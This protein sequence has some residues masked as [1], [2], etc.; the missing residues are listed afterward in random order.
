M[1]GFLSSTQPTLYCSNSFDNRD[2]SLE[3]LLILSSLS[4]LCVR[5]RKAK[6]NP[7]KRVNEGEIMIFS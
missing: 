6:N 4:N 2:L 3:S 1:L 7:F 5:G